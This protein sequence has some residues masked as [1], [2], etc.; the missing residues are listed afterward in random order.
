MTLNKGKSNCKWSNW[1]RTNLEQEN[2]STQYQ[3]NKQPSQK[4]GRRPK[5]TF[6]QT[7]QTGRQQTLEKMIRVTHH[8]FQFTS[9]AQS[10]PTLCDPM[11]HTIPGLFIH[12]QLLEATQTHV[13]WVGDAFN[14]LILCRPLLLL[15]SIFPSIRVFSNESDLRIRWPKYW[16]KCKS[17]LQWDITSHWSEWPSPK[18]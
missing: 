8:S 4:M 3:K 5:Q 9:V 7:R 15:P 10:C 13:H 2:F 16:E 11:N 6:L 1:Q 12:H 14:H 18:H 17:T